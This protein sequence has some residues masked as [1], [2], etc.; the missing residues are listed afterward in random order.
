MRL[1]HCLSVIDSVDFV[2]LLVG[3]TH[4]LPTHPEVTIN[5]ARAIVTAAHAEL[6]L[7]AN[8][9]RDLGRQLG[10]TISGNA[11][12][13]KYGEGTLLPLPN[14]RWIGK[15]TFECR[16]GVGMF[17]GIEVKRPG[18]CARLGVTELYS[19]KVNRW[20]FHLGGSDGRDHSIEVTFK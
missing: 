6:L 9:N 20:A 14:G 7:N 1:E 2:P 3:R 11:V 18:A 5:I 4:G 16:E 15:R 13:P 19:P 12:V 10:Y 8:G 17:Y